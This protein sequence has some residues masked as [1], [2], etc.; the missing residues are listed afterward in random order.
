MDEK[1]SARGFEN[2]P[3][4]YSKMAGVTSKEKIDQEHSRRAEM[5]R[6]QVI[7]ALRAG[8]AVA[9]VTNVSGNTMKIA[10][11]F[12]KKVGKAVRGPRK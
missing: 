6:V 1:K 2:T 3:I 8:V 7:K 9:G 12:A 4:V 11:K 5:Q 10:S